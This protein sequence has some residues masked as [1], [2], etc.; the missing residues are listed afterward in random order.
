MSLARLTLCVGFAAVCLAVTGC[1]SPPPGDWTQAVQREWVL[2]KINGRSP[3]P[4][5]TPTL[6][7]ADDGR[8][9]GLAGANRYFGTCET[10]PDGSAAF[11]SLGSTRMFLDQ[12]AGLMQQEQAFLAALGEV[13]EYRVTAEQLLFFADGKKRLVFTPAVE[14]SANPD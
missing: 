11:A 4:Q 3:L 9:A 7:I 8:V 12:P 2:Q 13:D 6:S 14:D 5:R 10:N 1:T